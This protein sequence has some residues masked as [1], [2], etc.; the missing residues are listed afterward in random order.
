[1]WVKTSTLWV[2]VLS[3]D[4]SVYW[5]KKTAVLKQDCLTSFL[6]W[7]LIETRLA[8]V[9]IPPVDEIQNTSRIQR[10]ALHYIT[11]QSD[12]YILVGALTKN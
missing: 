12:I 1:M 6:R 8:R 3:R 5:K 9:S 11:V 4:T 7:N 2:L 10:A